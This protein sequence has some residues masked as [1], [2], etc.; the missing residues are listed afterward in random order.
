[1]MLLA[2]VFFLCRVHTKILHFTLCLLL[3]PQIINGYR[4]GLQD[5]NVIMVAIFWIFVSIVIYKW[6]VKLFVF[7]Q[8]C[9]VRSHSLSGLPFSLPGFN[10]NN[11]DH[12]NF[13]AGQTHILN[14][15]CLVKFN[16][17]LNMLISNYC[18]ISSTKSLYY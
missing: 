13:S 11:I 1:M 9:D 2:G 17:Y 12:N 10:S 16:N 8:S 5:T 6:G 14:M 4:R 7:K 18:I 15:D 3:I